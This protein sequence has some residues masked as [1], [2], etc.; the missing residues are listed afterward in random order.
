MEKAIP[1]SKARMI[2][3]EAR[4]A[5]IETAPAAAPEKAARHLSLISFSLIALGGERSLVLSPNQLFCESAEKAPELAR[6]VAENTEFEWNGYAVWV[7]S[8]R[9]FSLNRIQYDCSA[10]KEQG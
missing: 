6:L 8:S 4:K 3:L 2:K 7:N 5:E 9:Q 1:V 10:V